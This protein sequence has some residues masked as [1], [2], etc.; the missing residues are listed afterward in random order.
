MPLSDR[1]LLLVERHLLPWP[2]RQQARLL[3]ELP[4]SCL[5]CRWCS[6]ISDTPRRSNQVRSKQALL[7]G[8]LQQ[9]ED[10]HSNSYRMNAFSQTDT[11]GLI[12]SCYMFSPTSF[13]DEQWDE[14]RRMEHRRT[15]KLPHGRG[16][17][18][19][20]E[21]Q[22]SVV[23]LRAGDC[24]TNALTILGT[25]DRQEDPEEKALKERH[26]KSRLHLNFVWVRIH[27]PN[28]CR[29]AERNGIFLLSPYSFLLL[30]QTGFDTL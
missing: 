7:Y 14:A 9:T 29:K 4:T 24:I 18:V 13:F 2:D 8:M 20:P 30:V 26:A 21:P 16:K 19:R 10:F 1:V 22:Q 28:I 3:H 23:T 25:D 11:K 6:K 5:S 12:S 15:S 27:L 17:I